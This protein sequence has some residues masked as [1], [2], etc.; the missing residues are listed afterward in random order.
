MLLEFH[1]DE[2]F[3]RV[4]DIGTEHPQT[5]RTLVRC[6][7]SFLLCIRNKREFSVELE[8]DLVTPVY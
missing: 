7:F 4:F 1:I 5:T 2:V 6:Y 3:P 8:L